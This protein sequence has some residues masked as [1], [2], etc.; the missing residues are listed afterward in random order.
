MM[1]AQPDPYRVAIVIYGGVLHNSVAIKAEPQA[2][3]L[4]IMVG[5][6]GFDDAGGMKIA[7][8][9]GRDLTGTVF[10]QALH[11]QGEAVQVI[12]FPVPAGVRLFHQ[13]IESGISGSGIMP[14][15]VEI[16]L[17][18]LAVCARNRQKKEPCEQKGS[19]HVGLLYTPN[20]LLICYFA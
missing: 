9:A 15:I 3:S 16:S 2:L 14:L 18:L 5:A 7:K 11:L 12:I 20:L 1:P 10:I 19:S 6:H 4:P 8:A 17:D 13:A